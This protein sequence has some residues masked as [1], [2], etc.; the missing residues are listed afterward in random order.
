MRPPAWNAVKADEE[1]LRSFN[2][3]AGPY[4]NQRGHN[5]GKSRAFP[6]ASTGQALRV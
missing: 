1:R 5:I 3:T 4:D 6:A 2:A